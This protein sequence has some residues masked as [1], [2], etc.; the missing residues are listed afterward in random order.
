MDVES[1][2]RRTAGSVDDDYDTRALVSGDVLAR[3]GTPDSET[4]DEEPA[5]HLISDHTGDTP[6]PK[7]Y[8]KKQ[9]PW[10]ARYCT[11]K[12]AII[13]CEVCVNVFDFL[14]TKK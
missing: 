11:E 13:P 14:D 12:L 9:P 2:R 4:T 7:L 8:I 5:S 6:L 1:T 10:R 3:S